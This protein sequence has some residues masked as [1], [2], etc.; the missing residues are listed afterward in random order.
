[1]PLSQH[2][3][4]I[5]ALAPDGTHQPFRKWI[6]PRALRSRQSSGDAQ[7]P[8]AFP[9]TLTVD[10]VPISDQ[11]SRRGVVGK[12][13]Q[14]L[15][16]DPSSRR[17]LGHV[18]MNDA[19][20]TRGQYHQN[21]QDPKS[22]G[23]HREEIDGNQF[24]HM[25]VEE[26]LPSL[27]TRST[28]SAQESR[29]GSLRDVDTELKQ[30]PMDAGRSPKWI[31][32]SHLEDQRSNGGAELRASAP[33]PG[34]PGPEQAKALAMPSYNRFRSHH[35]QRP[36]PILPTPE[37]PHPKRGNPSLATEVAGTSA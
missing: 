28:P 7:V 34:N 13:F 29:H 17:V 23:G 37:Q 8:E 15:L 36:A 30:L 4:M 6:L 20:P 22:H 33:A 11:I 5:Q 16:S 14:D 19:A 31:G 3:H 25:I 10:L 1:M 21:E 32:G 2:D 26:H 35:D 24:L 12:R 18:E 27:R 9:E